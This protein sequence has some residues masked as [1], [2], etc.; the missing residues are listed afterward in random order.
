M[1]KGA[2][3]RAHAVQR[4]GGPVVQHRVGFASLSPPYGDYDV[5]ADQ[6]VQG[7]RRP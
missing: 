2:K 3:R 4:S 7:V 5:A 6:C 1:G